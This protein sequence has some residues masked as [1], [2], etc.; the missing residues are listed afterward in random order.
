[1][2]SIFAL[3]VLIAL[4]AGGVWWFAL[5]GG[6][7]GE[8]GPA[9]ARTEEGAPPAR[10]E[11]GGSVAGETVVEE[12][13]GDGEIVVPPL[14]SGEGISMESSG[15]E[16]WIV[17]ALEWAGEFRA[18]FS[19]IGKLRAIEQG[20]YFLKDGEEA[21]DLHREYAALHDSL[22]RL[23]LPEGDG[24]LRALIAEL[25][26][27]IRDIITPLSQPPDSEELDAA[28]GNREPISPKIDALYALLNERRR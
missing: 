10:G 21:P 16:R 19:H 7:D 20:K 11:G 25:D 6:P 15:E 5:R 27:A 13:M 4:M 23:A 2:R 26:G 8:A 9:P 28:Y 17:E 22:K 3:I 14:L 18:V 12:E 1:M 24:E